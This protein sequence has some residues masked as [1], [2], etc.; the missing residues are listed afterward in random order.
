MGVKKTLDDI[1]VED[2]EAEP[3]RP[4]QQVE[5]LVPRE[6]LVFQNLDDAY[7]Y[8]NRYAWT[9]GFSIRKGNMRE[10]KLQ[11]NVQAPHPKTKVGSEA[12]IVLSL[13]RDGTYKVL[14]RQFLASQR[15]ISGV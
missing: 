13:Q 4:N 6:G 11:Q 3:K 10:D 14:R 9:K 15:T 5:D 2:V 8:Y 7:H 12:C 1:I